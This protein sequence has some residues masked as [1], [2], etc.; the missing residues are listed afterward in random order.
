V[1]RSW[2]G[3]HGQARLDWQLGR[4]NH[5]MARLGFVSW[6]EQNPLLGSDVFNGAGTSLKGR[7]LSGAVGVTSSSGTVANELRAGFSMAKREWLG[8]TLASIISLRYGPGSW[9]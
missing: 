2:K 5:L 7:D 8:A 1:V 9:N 4:T 3:G 6:K